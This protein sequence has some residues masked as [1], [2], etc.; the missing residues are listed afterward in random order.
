VARRSN[1]CDVPHCGRSIIPENGEYPQGNI[2]RQ[3][4]SRCNASRYYWRKRQS[5][6]AASIKLRR[7]RLAFFGDRLGW[8][9]DTRGGE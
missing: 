6:D 5:E 7:K 3:L 1:K 9:F 4:C 2:S 8:L